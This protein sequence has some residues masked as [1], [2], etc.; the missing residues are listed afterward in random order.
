MDLFFDPFSTD[1]QELAKV[2]KDKEVK[3]S[4][5]SSEGLRV[6]P[7]TKKRKK[8]TVKDCDI[9]FIFW[10]FGLIDETCESWR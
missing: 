4:S 1:N 9:F 5:S 3:V 8:M 6:T 7:W 2:Q 10:F